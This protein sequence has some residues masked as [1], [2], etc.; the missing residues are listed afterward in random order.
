MAFFI[1]NIEGSG[2]INNQPEDRERES[3]REMAGKRV[4]SREVHRPNHWVSTTNY[5]SFSFKTSVNKF[6]AFLLVL[7]CPT[8]ME[9]ANQL[10]FPL[11]DAFDDF[12]PK[13]PAIT[14]DSHHARTP[15]RFERGRPTNY[16]VDG[17]PL[18]ELHCLA[19]HFFF[20]FS[21]SLQK[22]LQCHL[23][24]QIATRHEKANT[25]QPVV[26]TANASSQM[27]R[28]IY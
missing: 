27:H 13:E 11:G 24:Q 7:D 18:P 20:H 28:T 5:A 1:G 21:S 16:A 14:S 17:L 19:S 26:T 9:H 12:I 15:R 22:Q 10:L 23:Q 3:S 4:V 25:L 8:G 6:V 2:A